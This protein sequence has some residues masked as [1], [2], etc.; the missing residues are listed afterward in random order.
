MAR[1][2]VE[3]G[4]PEEL[5]LEGTDRETVHNELETQLIKA[6]AGVPAANEAAWHSWLTPGS[7]GF[8]FEHGVFFYEIQ[9]ATFKTP[10]GNIVGGEDLIARYRKV[11][12]DETSTHGQG[13]KLVGQL[14]A[15]VYFT[16]HHREHQDRIEERVIGVN[17]PYSPAFGY[18]DP[19]YFEPQYPGDPVGSPVVNTNGAEQRI[20]QFTD[21]FPS[22]QGA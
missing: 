9:R 17:V 15:L 16:T 13:D 20:R 10:E 22:P 21:K 12:P 7:S 8:H 14:E 18:W 3:K 1:E 4:S 5:V 19:N 6:M 11:V 2:I